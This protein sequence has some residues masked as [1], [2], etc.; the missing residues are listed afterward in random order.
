[1]KKNLNML[2]LMM[3]F[4][5]IPIAEAK[6]YKWVD[7]E[8]NVHYGERPTGENSQEL[9]INSRGSKSSLEPVNKP[10]KKSIDADKLMKSM[11][12]DRLSRDE[13]RR[14]KKKAE[15]KRQ[16]R[17]VRA[18]DR[19]KRIERATSLYRLDKEGNRNTLSKN[20]RQQ[21]TEKAHADIK[22]WCK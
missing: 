18:R 7:A 14:K 11:E 15:D 13:K 8:G 3:L 6:I 19:L 16:M 2:L 17:C 4:F 20:Q 22:K 5:S 12:A 10:A 9:I 21:S 1:V